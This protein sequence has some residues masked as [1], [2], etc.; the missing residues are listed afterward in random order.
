M[1]NDK[2]E[3]AK[4]ELTERECG[5]NEGLHWAADWLLGQSDANDAVVKDFAQN[6]SDSIRAHKKPWGVERSPSACNICG[7]ECDG[8]KDG[9]QPVC[10][11][12][13]EDHDYEYVQ[14]DRR[15]ECKHCFQIAPLDWFDD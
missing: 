10:P 1:A 12:H 2:R 6:I 13:C 15:H 7:V 5:Y 3:Q 4:H 11:E 9:I 14:E 8:W